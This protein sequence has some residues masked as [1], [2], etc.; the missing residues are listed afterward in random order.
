[1]DDQTDA[2]PFV[3]DPA[4]R[5]ILG[6]ADRLRARGPVTLVEL[7]DGV[8]AW[9]VSD[10]GLLRKLLVDPRVSRDPSRHWAAWN[11]GE[12]SP[13]WPLFPWVAVSGMLNAYGPD[14]RRL[15]GPVAG[16]FTA[17]RVAALRPRIEELADGL[18]DGLAGLPA[19]KPVDLREHYTHPLPI[20][21]ICELSGVTD[22]ATREE[23]AHCSDVV[24][25]VGKAP[26]QV[27]TA[28]SRLRDILRDLVAGKRERPGDDI[29]SALIAARDGDSPPL[30]EDELVDTLMAFVTAGHETTANLLC[31][32]IV[33]LLTRPGQLGRVLSGD[34][35]WTD[36]IEE[37]LRSQPPIP[38]MPLRYAVEDMDVNGVTLHAGEAIIACFAAA[39]RDPLVY[40]SDAG[41]FDADRAFK[42]HLAFGYGAHH[43]IG[44]PLARLEASI[45]LPAIFD[46][47]P[48]L[49]LAVEPGE[50]LPLESFVSSGYRALPAW[51]TPAR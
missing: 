45:A 25:N 7:P 20:T 47:Y 3:F 49:T 33:A 31:N 5:D 27:A 14:H 32:A 41:L 8:R 26:E 9:A 15:R 4:G 43:C 18:L 24:F 40:G 16:A 37:S 30:S 38:S 19:D 42:D 11:R 48:G 29:S 13:D 2:P 23:V 22:E 1:M 21:V 46:R 35:P 34:V 51:L 17:R 36:V 28:F 6:E 50:L 10:Q 12:I 39:G 44:A